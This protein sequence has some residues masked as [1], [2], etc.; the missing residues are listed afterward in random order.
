[1]PIEAS[2]KRFKKLLETYGGNKKIFPINA[3][4]D[5]EGKKS[6]DNFLASNPDTER[7]HLLSIDI[8]AMIT[9]C[10]G[11]LSYIIRRVVVIEFNPSIPNDIR[12]CPEKRLE[13]QSQQFSSC[14]V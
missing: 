9:Q 7:L 2:P 13:R 1:V 6:L 5:F 10:L 12:V 14:F 11:S 3:L 4:V 8:T